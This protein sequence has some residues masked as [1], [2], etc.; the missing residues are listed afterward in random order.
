MAHSWLFALSLCLV[1]QVSAQMSHLRGLLWL[2]GPCQP[3]ISLNALLCFIP[4]TSSLWR[5]TV[6][7]SILEP[8]VTLVGGSIYSSVSLETVC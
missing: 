7:T 5:G 8:T 3:P 1:L 6:F 4:A 2:T